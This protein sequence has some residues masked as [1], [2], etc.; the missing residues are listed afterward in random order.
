LRV[1]ERLAGFINATLVNAIELIIVSVA[2]AKHEDLVARSSLVGSILG[3]LQLILGFSL[4]VGGIRFPKEDFIIHA[5]KRYAVFLFSGVSIIFVLAIYGTIHIKEQHDETKQWGFLIASRAV[6][7]VQL[8][9]YLGYLFITRKGW[10]GN[11]TQQEPET[12]N[13]SGRGPSMTGVVQGR[14]EMGPE[15]STS[16]V[17]TL[18]VVATGL[19]VLTAGWLIDSIKELA[20]NHRVSKQFIGLALIPIIGKAIECVA[21]LTASTRNELTLSVE[22]AV[23]GSV[24]IMWLA[25]PIT[26]IIGWGIGL[27]ITL[28][29]QPYEWIL[30]FVAGFSVPFSPNFMS[31][32]GVK[33]GLAFVALFCIWGLAMWI[34]VD[35]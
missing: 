14:R 10:C 32:S 31:E 7:V 20:E 8:T 18:L 29:I 30:P 24:Q 13:Y 19:I 22:A 17:V 34:D 16:M 15:L 5:C 35:R 23:G 3:N 25:I 12:V 1:G 4:F 33:K 26:I 11:R 28:P 21:V 2:L 6:A 27:Q 9:L